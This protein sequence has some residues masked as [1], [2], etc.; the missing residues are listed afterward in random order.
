MR[1]LVF[2][3]VILFY[4]FITFGKV[5]AMETFT[6][7]N[8]LPVIFETRKNTG[9]VA[10]QVWVKVGSKYE[11]PRIAGITHFIEHLIFK[12]TAEVKAGE[13]AS[14]I[15]SLGGSVN[16]FTSYDNTVYHI[17]V[18][19]KSFEEGLGLLLDAVKNPAFPET[20]I[21]KEKR[22]VLEEIKMGE[23]DPHRKLFK[24]L[25][26][27]SYEGHP[28]GR[29]I[30]GFEETV[31]NISREDILAYFHEHYTPDNM[32]VVITGDFDTVKAREIISKF[33][34]GFGDEK[35][36]VFA[37]TLIK[38]ETPAQKQK[39]IERSVRESYVSISYPVPSITH[40]DTVGLEVLAKILGD[41]DSSRL[42]DQLKF[43]KG[44]VTNI[45]TYLFSP[46]EDGLFIIIATF[47]GQAFDNI[48]K[49]MD[50]VIERLL[51]SGPTE[52]EVEK[53]KNMI[54]AS[55]IYSSE[56]AQGAARLFG[57]YQ[58]LTGDP[59]YPDKY[60]RALDKI[61]LSDITRLLK[62]YLVGK[63]RKLAALVPKQP[64]NPHIFTMKNGM[65]YVVNKNPSSPSFAF[66]IGFVG[67]LRDEPLGKNGA[68]NILS[69]M[70]MKGTKTKNAAVIAKEI[71]L[72]AGDISP[73]N[74][75]NIFGLSGKFL[76]KD[77]HK[78]FAL[79]KELLTETALKE[80]ELKKVKEDVLSSLRQRDDDPISFTFRRFTEGL[81]KGHPYSKDP[82][83]SEVDIQSIT[84][85]NVTDFYKQYV[86]PA[87][88]VLAISGDI[89]EKTIQEALDGLFKGWNG[90]ANVLGKDSVVTRKHEVA[91]DRDMMQ[92]HLIFGFL[93][94]GLVDN[95]RYAVEVMDAVLSGMGGRIHKVLREEN[96]YAYAL[97][98]FNQMA[99]DF[100]GIGIYIGTN[101]KLVQEVSRIAKSEIQKIVKDG[102]SEEEVNN[103]KSYLVGNHYI[104]M[105]S[106][107]SIAMSMCLDTMYGMKPGFFKVWPQHIEKVTLSDVNR[108]ARKYLNLDKMV[109]V[110]VGAG[111]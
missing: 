94:P 106:N 97:T 7:D 19:T 2:Y 64:L 62:K 63:E 85:K 55:Y 33:V 5:C 80:E 88:A 68:F 86:T 4:I 77:F 93:G 78:A 81:Y 61:S 111:E 98:F 90:P 74:G 20:E 41:G 72:L 83:G 11:E 71:E 91:V 25:F 96:P 3:Y 32:S 28:Y 8:R 47:K 18:P 1:K 109:S 48:T 110:R 35:T 73:Y 40:D 69:R 10:A 60:L 108:V 37:T 57:N 17:V 52:E 13:M 42:Q 31:K 14:R 21:T 6:L 22:V 38:P 15:E 34:K 30:I 12:G 87:K 79:L 16:A 43:K 24:E 84:L 56:T 46:K 75:R 58:T 76:A 9:V 95:D 102:F 39:V 103:A 107:S 44:M 104:S 82:M 59:R 54:R 26:S 100:G 49:A 89:D 92:T 67:G 101:R 36:G 27:M 29:P 45:S 50:E 105:Q 53:A 51:Q 99:F 70:L 65:S 23:D 66:M